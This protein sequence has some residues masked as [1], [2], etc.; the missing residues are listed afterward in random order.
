MHF[1]LFYIRLAVIVKL[2]SQDLLM[3]NNTNWCIL[4]QWRISIARA[5][6][7]VYN[8]PVLVSYLS[9]LS[10]LKESRNSILA[11]ARWY[12]FAYVC[13]GKECLWFFILIK[14]TF[15]TYCDH[16][17]CTY[18]EFIRSCSVGGRFF[19]IVC[20]QYFANMIFVT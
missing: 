2:N 16:Y 3:K 17:E 15:R 11:S 1:S 8:Q 12:W 10:L 6:T 5:H 20:S 7:N 9:I 18:S 13:R 14:I 19:D 4:I